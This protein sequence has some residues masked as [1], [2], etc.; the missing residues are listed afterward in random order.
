MLVVFLLNSNNLS[1]LMYKMSLLS[2]SAL[3]LCSLIAWT[4]ELN[5]F[6]ETDAIEPTEHFVV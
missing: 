6:V 2:E 5:G 4:S 3:E 1:F